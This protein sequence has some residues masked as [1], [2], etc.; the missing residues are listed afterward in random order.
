MEDIVSGRC[1]AL[2]RVVDHLGCT[3]HLVEIAR[4][5]DAARARLEGAVEPTKSQNMTVSWRRSADAAVVSC[6]RVVA[7]KFTS[8][9]GAG[10]NLAIAF[11]MRIR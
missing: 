1:S 7:L 4:G 11:R 9:M 2:H 5:A 6:L 10:A 3:L 8:A